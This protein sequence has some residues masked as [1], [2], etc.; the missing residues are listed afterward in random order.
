MPYAAFVLLGVAPQFL[1]NMLFSEAPLMASILPEGI[2][3]Q[4]H[5]VAGFMI[6]NVISLLYL[7]LQL[8]KS[9][10]YALLVGYWFMSILSALAV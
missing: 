5:I 2:A 1:Q 7:V 8:V 10:P 4:A 9:I 6:A 3:I